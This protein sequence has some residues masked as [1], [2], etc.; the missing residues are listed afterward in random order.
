MAAINDW[1]LQRVRRDRGGK[2]PEAVTGKACLLQG[3]KWELPR[4][5]PEDLSCQ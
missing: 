2:N 4:A 3:K 1:T 5:W